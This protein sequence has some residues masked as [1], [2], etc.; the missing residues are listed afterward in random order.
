MVLGLCCKNKKFHIFK[1]YTFL[2]L[3][4]KTLGPLWKHLFD[5][6]QIFL[7]KNQMRAFRVL[8]GF[9][10]ISTKMWTIE[11]YKTWYSYNKSLKPHNYAKNW[12]SCFFSPK[13]LRIFC[14]NGVEF[15][16][17][18]IN[19]LLRRVKTNFWAKV[20]IEV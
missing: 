15:R 17:F 7:A 6:L 14:P 8:L 18:N 2:Y 9:W 1:F 3:Y 19:S 4:T 11:K 10:C 5:F 20:N 12:L 16:I 13:H